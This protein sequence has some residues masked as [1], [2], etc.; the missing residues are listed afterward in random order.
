LVAGDPSASEFHL[1]GKK[2]GTHRV[3]GKPDVDAAGVTV[4]AALWLVVA[5]IVFVLAALFPLL[6]HLWPTAGIFNPW[7]GR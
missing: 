3:N 7:V 1:R 6:D 2:A 4:A 5:F